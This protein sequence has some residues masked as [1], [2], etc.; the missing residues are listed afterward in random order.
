MGD[1]V[2]EKVEK[3]DGIDL[4]L[5]AGIGSLVSIVYDGWSSKR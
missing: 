2:M 3:L 5:V 1:A 4:D